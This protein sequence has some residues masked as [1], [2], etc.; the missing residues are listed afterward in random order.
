M[1][2]SSFPLLDVFLE[3][4]YFFLFFLWI[5]ILFRV[6][7]DLF[8]SHDL[9]G[10]H[11]ALWFVFLL[12]VPFLGVFVYLIARGGKMAEHQ[13]QAIQSQ[14]QAMDDYIKTTAGSSTADELAKL[15]ELK[16]KGAISESEY[17][18]AKAEAIG[19]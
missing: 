9:G 4:L 19:V 6:L 5:L 10:L 15:H 2:A 14:Q 8:R 17:E 18:T 7:T 3:I 1:L 16:E 13:A 11:K 12:L